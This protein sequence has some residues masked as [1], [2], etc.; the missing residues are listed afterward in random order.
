MNINYEFY[1][2]FFNTLRK[3]H[4]SLFST[5]FHN[6]DVAHNRYS[7]KVHKKYM[8]KIPILVTLQAYNSRRLL[9]TK[10]LYPDKLQSMGGI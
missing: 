3:T 7:Q 9:F 4:I 2:I 1:M 6:S 10:S 5:F 8:R